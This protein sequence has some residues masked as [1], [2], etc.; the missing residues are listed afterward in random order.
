M[1][2]WDRKQFIVFSRV[3]TCTMKPLKYILSLSILI[4]MSLC[5]QNW[6]LVMPN[7]TLVYEEDRRMRYFSTVWV[8]SIHSTAY[9]TSYFMNRISPGEVIDTILYDSGCAS[10]F[11]PPHPLLVRALHKPQFCGGVIKKTNNKWV[12]SYGVSQFVIYLNKQVGDSWVCDSVLN[13]T[14]TFVSKDTMFLDLYQVT[15]SIRTLSFLNKDFV[16]SK[17][18]GIISNFDL[19]K[20]YLVK[21]NLI[22]V[23]NLGLGDVIPMEEHFFHYNVGDVFVRWV[24]NQNS[25]GMNIDVSRRTVT[26]KRIAGDTLIYD[27]YNRALKY[28]PGMIPIVDAF[29]NTMASTNTLFFDTTN[30][31]PDVMVP[32]LVYKDI[33]GQ[34]TKGNSY[35]SPGYCQRDSGLIEI[36][37]LGPFCEYQVDVEPF[38]EGF[39]NYFETQE[40]RLVGYIIDGIPHGDTTSV[41]EIDYSKFIQIFPNPT[42][43]LINITTEQINGISILEM[44]DLRGRLIE[45][46]TFERDL[47]F[48]VSTYQNGIY[49][50]IIK[51]EVGAVLHREK[52]VIQ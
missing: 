14:M 10:S 43:N 28:W 29:P 48:D 30:H 6:S 4:S 27:Y 42:N 45:K 50:A 20:T 21:Y 11:F 15:D 18:H 39:G 17:N 16:V 23:Q 49:F 19:T 24:V 22:G 12:V 40:N 1:K 34:I 52:V 31:S 36:E 5:A 33:N 41:S 51:N 3:N 35:Y 38:S 26:G 32:V 7:D 2:F 47:T 44:Y 9:D 37:V 8:D 46:Q 25:D 13:D